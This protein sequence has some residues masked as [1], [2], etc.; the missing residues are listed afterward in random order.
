MGGLILQPG[1]IQGEKTEFQ[2]ASAENLLPLLSPQRFEDCLENLPLRNLLTFA[3][4]NVLQV[5]CFY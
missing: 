1:S 2:W 5:T 4:S 3:K